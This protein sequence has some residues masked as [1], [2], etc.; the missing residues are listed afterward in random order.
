MAQFRACNGVVKAGPV[1]T[2]VIV[3]ELRNW[4]S[5]SEADEIDTSSMGTCTKSSQ[6]GAVKTSIEVGC[7]WDPADAGQAEFVPGDEIEIEIYPDGEDPGKT[8]YA[9]LLRVLTNN[10]SG[11]VDGVVEAEFT[12]TINGAFPSSTVP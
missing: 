2:P 11:D 8:F 1:G 10:I 6:A 3:G 9:G 7:W 12:G 5:S 4:A